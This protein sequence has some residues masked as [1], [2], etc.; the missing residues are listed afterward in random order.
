MTPEVVTRLVE[1][2]MRVVFQEVGSSQA[3]D[4][5]ADDRDSHGRLPAGAARNKKVAKRPETKKRGR[6]E[7]RSRRSVGTQGPERLRNVKLVGRVQR[8][9]VVKSEGALRKFQG[10]CRKF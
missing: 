9:V 2:D 10:R 1:G 6:E 3:R 8:P 7:K 5:G 4:A